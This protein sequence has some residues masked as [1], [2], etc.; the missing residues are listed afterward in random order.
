MNEKLYSRITNLFGV[1][2]DWY[3]RNC[4]NDKYNPCFKFKIFLLLN[5]ANFK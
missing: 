4:S 1:E 3:E 5:Y 2:T